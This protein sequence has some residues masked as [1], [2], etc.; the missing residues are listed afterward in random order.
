MHLNLRCHETKRLPRVKK[1][2]FPELCDMFFL[3]IHQLY[4][5][6]AKEWLGASYT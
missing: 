6:T 5:A 2:A 3:C 4:R 1:K